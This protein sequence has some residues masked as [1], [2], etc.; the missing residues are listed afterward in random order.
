MKTAEDEKGEKVRTFGILFQVAFSPAALVTTE[1]LRSVAAWHGSELFLERDS[2][3]PAGRLPAGVEAIL[4]FPNPQGGEQ[5]PLGATECV[6][7]RLH[8]I[9]IFLHYHGC[10]LSCGEARFGS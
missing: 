4:Q 6:N 2:T 7:R 1:M 10:G 5:Q 3:L 9:F 8:G